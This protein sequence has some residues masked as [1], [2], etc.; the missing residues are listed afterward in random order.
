MR[1]IAWLVVTIF[2]LALA[3]CISIHGSTNAEAMRI[4][5]Q[6]WSERF[7][8]CGD[9]YFGK[10]DT[11]S[12]KLIEIYQYK[13][14]EIAVDPGKI[15]EADKLNGVEWKGKTYLKPKAHRWWDSSSKE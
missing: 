3:N 5:R 2:L 11:G 15:V 7:G 6:I 9:S 12:D 4:A 10:Y 13:D 14:V 1:L 8:K